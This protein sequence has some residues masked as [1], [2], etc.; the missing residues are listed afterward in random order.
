MRRVWLVL[1]MA[2][3]FTRVGL[4]APVAKPVISQVHVISIHVP[5]HAAF[6]AVFLWLRDVIQLPRVYGEPSK[7]GNKEERLYAGFSV[8]NAYLE[9]CGPYSSDA[10]FSPDR[11]A[12]FHGLT[13]SPATSL[14]ADVKEME[15]R[16]ISNTGLSGG[17]GRFRF[18]HLSDASMSGSLLSVGLWEIEDKNDRVN[19]GFVSSLLQ[20]AKGGALGVKR[21]E[22]VRVGHSGKASLE[23]WA[24]FL[25]PATREGDAWVVG[26]GPVLRLVPSTENRIESIVLK[27]ESIEKAKAVLVARNLVGKQTSDGVELDPA[28]AFGLRIILK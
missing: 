24:N 11:P 18:T 14:P 27:V 23:Q 17:G 1:M 4:S 8:G 10:P 15:R 7:P 5:D 6:D 3:C 16:G 9:P 26:N 28:K 2:C 25:A 13:C 20:E 21:I 12:R 19:L 22:E